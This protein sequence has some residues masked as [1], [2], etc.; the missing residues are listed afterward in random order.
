MR[1]APLHSYLV[2]DF[3]HDRATPKFVKWARE[4]T[5][6]KEYGLWLIG[7]YPASYCRVFM[8][9]NA[10]RFFVPPTEFLGTYNMGKR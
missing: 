3:S 2:Q 5:L 7:H 4:G 8:L 1:E 6:Y 9:P 10:I